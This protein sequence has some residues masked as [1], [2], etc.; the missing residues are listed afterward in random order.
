MKRLLWTQNT[1]GAGSASFF[2]P[3]SS[4]ACAWDHDTIDN[5][6][7]HPDTTG[8]F[9]AGAKYEGQPPKFHGSDVR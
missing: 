8:D 7:R 5:E 3:D 4:N 6:S 2:L 1:F 9:R